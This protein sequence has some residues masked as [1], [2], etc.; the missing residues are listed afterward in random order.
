MKTFYK[1]I[2]CGHITDTPEYDYTKGYVIKTEGGWHKYVSPAGFMLTTDSIA[3]WVTPVTCII[4]CSV[5]REVLAYTN[6]V[7]VGGT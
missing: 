7:T 6:A 3:E 4:R 5:C 1:C 2:N